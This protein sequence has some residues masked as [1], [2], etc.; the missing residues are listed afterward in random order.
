VED[1]NGA[2]VRG[3]GEEG[4]TALVEAYC[5]DGFLVETKRLVGFVGK[6]EVVPEQALDSGLVFVWLVRC[7]GQ[8]LPCRRFRQ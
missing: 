6:V 8:D 3:V 1:L 2:V 5:A 4:E 7:M